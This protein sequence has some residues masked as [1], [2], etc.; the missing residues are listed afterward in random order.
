[1]SAPPMPAG[2]VDPKVSGEAPPPYP[3]A[4]PY[5]AAP[6]Y[7]QQPP[8][9]MQGPPTNPVYIMPSG[10][11]TTS[12]VYAAGAIPAGATTTT[13][14]VTGN[15]PRCHV[16]MLREESNAAMCIVVAILAILFFPI[17]LLYFLCLP[18]AIMHRCDHCGYG[19]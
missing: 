14:I 11:S 1:M 12:T 5:G 7:G 6:T 8:P 16:G 9:M 4:A 3:G 18:A 13:V 19:A 2:Y 15:C 10:H 17:G